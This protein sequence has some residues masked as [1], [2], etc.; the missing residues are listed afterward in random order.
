MQI[1][2]KELN[3]LISQANSIL[4]T[5]PQ[6]PS[7]DIVATAAAWQIFLRQQG[8]VADIYLTGKYQVWNFFPKT[9]EIKNDLSSANKFQIVLDIAKV[10]VKQ[11]SYDIVDKELRIN[12]LPED[13]NFDSQD[14]KIEKGHLTYNLIITLG[15]SSLDSLGNLFAEHKR[16]F[17]DTNIINIDRS[18]LNENFGQLNIVELSS[19]ALA[20]ISY[21]FFQSQ[22]SKELSTCLLSGIIAA[23]NS[24][25][26]PLVTPELLEIASQLIVGGADRQSIIEGLYRTKDIMTLKNWGRIL[27]RLKQK[28]QIIYSHL[29][30]ADI[31]TLPQDFQELVK[32]LMLSTPD[33]RLA[34][35]FYQVELEKTEAWIYAVD[36]INVWNLVRDLNPQGSKNMVKLLIDFSLDKSRDLLI[37]KLAE[38]MK[39]LGKE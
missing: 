25:Q 22:L 29:E 15:V 37:N 28:G 6:D 23:T 26:S 11:L 27:S 8:K 21:Y 30:H 24:F 31:D 33:T 18:I 4:I 12:I 1:P 32:D 19:T 7:I 34:I 16:F 5:G 36:N 35:I 9:L 13:G 10:G 38:A 14:V 20:E 3:N 2:V 17:H 39:F